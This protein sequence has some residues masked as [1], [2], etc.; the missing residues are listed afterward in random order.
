MA[1]LAYRYIED[2]IGSFRHL[3]SSVIPHAHG[4]PADFANPF[5]SLAVTA[6]SMWQRTHLSVVRCGL[7]APK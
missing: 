5:V 1:A 2:V 6:V 4:V 7:L 3:V